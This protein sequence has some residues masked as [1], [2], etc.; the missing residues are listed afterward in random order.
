M[1]PEEEQR[2][3]AEHFQHMY[4]QASEGKCGFSGMTLADCKRSICD[5]FEFPWVKHAVPVL[6]EDDGHTTKLTVGDGT[7]DWLM[8]SSDLTRD[9]RIDLI[10]RLLLTPCLV[11]DSAA[12]QEDF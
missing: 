5:C 1:K 11:V 4:E 10:M 2:Q 12:V 8:V 3:R 6:I 9:E 7:E